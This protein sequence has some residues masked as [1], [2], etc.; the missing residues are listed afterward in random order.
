L[1]VQAARL[2]AWRAAEPAHLHWIELDE[3]VKWCDQRIAAHVRSDAQATKAS[4]LHGIGPIGASALVASVGD[5]SHSANARQFGAW[6]GLVPRQN[7]SGGKRG[8]PHPP[9]EASLG[10]ITKRGDDYLRT[11]LIQGAKSAVT[12]REQAQ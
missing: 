11:L 10:P 9:R 5:F 1:A 7:S 3:E 8:R 6:L 2:R 12:E 4:A